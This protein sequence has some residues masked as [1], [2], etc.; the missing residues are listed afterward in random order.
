MCQPCY[1]R[2]RQLE[3][4]QRPCRI[5]ACKGS[6]V[7]SREQQI[8]DRAKGRDAVRERMCEG[9]YERFKT[10]KDLEV[11]CRVAGC[12]NTWRYPRLPYL[13]QWVEAGTDEPP[14][15]PSR[16]CPDCSKLY[17]TLEDREV[18]CKTPGCAGT[19]TDRRGAQLN[20]IRKEE[21]KDPPRRLCPDCYELLHKLEDVEVE[22]KNEGCTRTWTW[23]RASRVRAIK[24]S[25]AKRAGGGVDIE[26]VEPPDRMCETC[27]EFIRTHPPTVLACEECGSETAWSTENQLRVF[28][29]EWKEPELCA[30]CLRQRETSRSPLTQ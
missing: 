22:C 7:Y 11:E 30:D 1:E 20:R 24:A 16:M 12:S 3:D 26:R 25:G 21:S 28:L 6:W 10:L 23:K 14:A 18:E 8:R 9:C 29:G 15:P 27:E 19:W 17:S 5:S 2:F 4:E 13:Q